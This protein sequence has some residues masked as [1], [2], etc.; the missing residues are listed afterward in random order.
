ML[1]HKILQQRR[2]EQRRV[3]AEHEHVALEP[4][5]G[6]ARGGDSV[7]AAA[8]LLLDRDLGPFDL[9][10]RLADVRGQNHDE[11][12]GLERPHCIDRPVHEPSAEQRVKLLRQP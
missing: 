2:R 9:A 7:A 10:D 6:R 11:P 5:E 8:R 4:N 3:S 12:S 1:G